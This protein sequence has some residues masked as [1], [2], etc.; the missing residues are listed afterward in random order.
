M[1]RPPVPIMRLDKYLSA[2]GFGSRSEVKKLLRQGIVTVNGAPAGD[3]GLHVEPGVSRVEC[4]GENAAYQEH[5]YVMLHKPA[6]VVSA[7]ADRWS[8]TALDLLEGAYPGRKLFPAG[9][10]D[11]DATGLLLITDDGPLAHEL[12]SP[13]KHVEKV[14]EVLLDKPVEHADIEAFASGIDLGDFTAKP[15]MLTAL[16]GNR[17]GVALTE[18]KFHEVK[19]MFE[20]RGKTVLELK[21]T[22]MGSLRLDENL[23]PGEWRELTNEE[24]AAL[25]T[26]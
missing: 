1:N 24:E 18:G 11:R 10:L 8:D 13:K 22:A 23:K 19:R 5:V 16:P 6:G 25:K 4:N 12:L 15:A 26:N 20:A 14:Y 9:R 7:T 3:P 2:C 21:R 17:A